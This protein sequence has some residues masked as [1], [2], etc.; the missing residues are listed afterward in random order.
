ME[1][2]IIVNKTEKP[3]SFEFGK[4]SKRMKIYFSDVAD[5]QEKLN[6]LKK[7]GIITEEDYN[8]K[9]KKDTQWMFQKNV[10]CVEAQDTK[11]ESVESVDMSM[12]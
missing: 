10:L 7:A 6:E 2:Q 9:P 12:T 3:H 8:E 11:K 4:A 5:L 1:E